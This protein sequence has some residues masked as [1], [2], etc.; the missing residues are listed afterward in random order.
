MKLPRPTSEADRLDL[1]AATRQALDLA[2]PSKFAL[3]TRVEV[4]ALSNY[5]SPSEMEKFMPVDVVVDL[6]RDIGSPI[7]VEEM[8]RLLGFKLVPLDPEEGGD[9]GYEDIADLSREGGDVVQ[10]LANGLK[11]GRLDPGE[12]R[13]A[14]RE[15]AENVAV[16]RRLDRKIA[17]GR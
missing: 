12:R 8:A 16:L 11:D 2:R 9:V 6:C 5:S 7:L 3:I 17:G 10:T 4:P 14:R 15:I 13:E 1:K